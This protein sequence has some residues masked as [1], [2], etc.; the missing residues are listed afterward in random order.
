VLIERARP[1]SWQPPSAGSRLATN[2]VPSSVVAIQA[3]GRVVVAG[4]AEDSGLEWDFALTRYDTDGSLDSSFGSGGR[5]RTDFAPGTAT[6]EEQANSIVVMPNGRIVVGGWTDHGGSGR[7][8]ALARYDLLGQL[9]TTF[10]NNGLTATDFD[11]GELSR[12]RSG[13]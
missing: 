9:D 7:N 12:R 3:D 5:V 4:A 6:S 10:S 8:F 11:G 1:T 2:T 13:R